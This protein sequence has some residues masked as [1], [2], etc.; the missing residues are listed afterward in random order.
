MATPERIDYLAS[1]TP[2]GIELLDEDGDVVRRLDATEA[3]ALGDFLAAQREAIEAAAKV[4][5]WRDRVE[6]IVYNVVRA[7]VTPPKRISVETGYDA[8]AEVMWY[9]VSAVETFAAV[10]GE[11][12]TA[13]L[14]WPDAQDDHAISVD[15]FVVIDGVQF[16]AWEDD[17]GLAAM[18][19]SNVRLVSA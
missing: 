15:F 12:L 2:R 6:K 16:Y 14:R 1:L 5:S 11:P 19:A 8:T 17:P 3:L 7:G 9:D 18:L 13:R 4:T 10:T